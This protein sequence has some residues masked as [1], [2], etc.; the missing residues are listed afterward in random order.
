MLAWTRSTVASSSRPKAPASGA[1]WLSEAG[2]GSPCLDASD[3]C[4][5]VHAGASAGCVSESFRFTR[6]RCRTYPRAYFRVVILS[7]AAQPK[8]LLL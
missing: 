8:D 3:G 5:V 1:S 2:G 6:A 7:G 4:D